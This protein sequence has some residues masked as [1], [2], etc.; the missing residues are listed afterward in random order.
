M[1]KD[2]NLGRPQY[3]KGEIVYFDFNSGREVQEKTGKIEVVDAY[4]TYF[5][6]DEVS[7]DILGRD[8]LYKHIVES[9]VRKK[10]VYS[11]GI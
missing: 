6:K 7:Y 11:S 10:T 9:K 4:G 3:Q 5:Q 1:G 2:Y 8:G